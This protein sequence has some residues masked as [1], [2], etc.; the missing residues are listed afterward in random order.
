[1]IYK[2]LKVLRMY[3]QITR[4]V[5][6]WHPNISSLRELVLAACL[7]HQVHISVEKV[8]IIILLGNR[9]NVILIS[10]SKPSKNGEVNYFLMCY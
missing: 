9:F 5:I 1:M 7:N 8:L 4:E 3:H 6:Q 2:G 10:Q